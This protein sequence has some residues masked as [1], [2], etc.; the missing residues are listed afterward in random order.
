MFKKQQSVT[1]TQRIY[2]IKTTTQRERLLQTTET[3]GATSNHII[4]LGAEA[5]GQFDFMVRFPA[6][7][8]ATTAGSLWQ[9]LT[10]ASAQRCD[11]EQE[12]VL[13]GAVK[14]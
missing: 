8:V 12:H 14:D 4:C 11:Q 5:D 9:N 3:S 13:T 1:S 2:E 10:R 6:V 7:F